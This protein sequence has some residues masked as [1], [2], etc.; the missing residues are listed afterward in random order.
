MTATTN[1]YNRISHVVGAE[2][3]LTSWVVTG[4]GCTHWQDA[5]GRSVHT[6]QARSEMTEC[7]Q[8]KT[9][10]KNQ[11]LSNTAAVS[12][13]FTNLSGRDIQGLIQSPTSEKTR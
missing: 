13:P 6:V 4:C 5:A 3:A 2:W 1:S 12:F 8:I 9:H 7:G 10:G 11:H